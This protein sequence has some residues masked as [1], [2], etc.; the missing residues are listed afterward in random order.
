[1]RSIKSAKWPSLTPEVYQTAVQP[2]V[3]EGP[4]SVQPP[5]SKGPTGVQ[6]P[7]PQ[8]LNAVQPTP[9]VPE[10]PNVILY[11]ILYLRAHLE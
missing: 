7:V 9:A 5:I 10:G 6:P 1:V 4:N 8:G 2:P 3:P 11:I